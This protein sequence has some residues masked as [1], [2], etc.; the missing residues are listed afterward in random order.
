MLFHQLEYLLRLP[1]LKYTVCSLQQLSFAAQSIIDYLPLLHQ[2]EYQLLLHQLEYLLPPLIRVPIAASP[3][4]ISAC[5]LHQ[6]EYLLLLL[7]TK[8]SIPSPQTTVSIAAPPSC[9]NTFLVCMYV[10]IP[11]IVLDIELQS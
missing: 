3:I 8:V 7:P 2:L 5:W 10:N 1:Q 11:K 6:L 4:R 9:V